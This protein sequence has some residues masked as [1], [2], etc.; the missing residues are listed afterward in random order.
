MPRLVA[1][2]RRLRGHSRT[3]A[4]AS[5]LTP[6]G[7]R[8]CLWSPEYSGR[9]RRPRADLS[10]LWRDHGARRA[11]RRRKPRWRLGLSRMR[12]AGRGRVNR[13]PPPESSV[14]L[15]SSNCGLAPFLRSATVPPGSRRMSA[16]CGGISRGVSSLTT[17]T[18]DSQLATIARGRGRVTIPRTGC[19]RGTL[20]RSARSAL[21]ALVASICS[22]PYSDGKTLASSSCA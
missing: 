9:G 20:N 1:E 5:G 21:Y 3:L 15:G 8:C 2:L 18:Y 16:A 10:T 12:G 11:Q 4:Q 13:N 19:Q 22:S 6:D 14:G 7:T 17:W